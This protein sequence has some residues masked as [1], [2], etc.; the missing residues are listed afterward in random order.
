MEFLVKQ[1]GQFLGK[2]RD[3]GQLLQG[4]PPDPLQGFEPVQEG[5]EP[6]GTD[7]LDLPEQRGDRLT[8]PKEAVIAHGKT[9]GLIPDPLKEM[10]SLQVTLEIDGQ[11]PPRDKDLLFPFRQGSQSISVLELLVQY[12]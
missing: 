8:I 6:R 9:V 12:R 7:T 2:S 3:R 10:T 5:P 11:G 4:S 1:M